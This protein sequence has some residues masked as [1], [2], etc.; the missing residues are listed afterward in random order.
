[1]RYSKTKTRTIAAAVAAAVLMLFASACSSDGS[2][3]GAGSTTTAAVFEDVTA[4][5]DAALPATAP[6]N[7]CRTCRRD[8]F[9]GCAV[10]SSQ[11][12]RHDRDIRERFPCGCVVFQSA[13]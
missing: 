10:H 7:D 13:W 8:G 1:M 9:C 3:N 4:T 6:T 11:R 12:D 2:G 5:T